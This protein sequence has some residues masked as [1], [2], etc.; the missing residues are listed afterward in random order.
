[1]RG[2]GVRCPG[3]R[4]G[5]VRAG[6]DPAPIPVPKPAAEHGGD[7]M[8][9]EGGR[10]GTDSC[11]LSADPQRTAGS[12]P[13]WYHGCPVPDRMGQFLFRAGDTPGAADQMATQRDT[14]PQI[15]KRDTD[16]SEW[17]TAV[18]LRAELADYTPVRGFM[19]IRPYGY[20]LWEGIQTWLDRKFK[21]TGH[22][23][24]YFPLLVPE[25]YLQ[26]EAEHR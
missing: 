20:A 23:T 8:S 15:P 16:F 5:G 18:A 7:S 14:A 11:R 24:A 26:K 25:S 6:P 1:M 22:V 13:G 21:E 3:E 12:E 9:T 10:E 19:A 17:Y 2:A 4:A